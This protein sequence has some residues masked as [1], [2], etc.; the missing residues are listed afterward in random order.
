MRSGGAVSCHTPARVGDRATERELYQRQVVRTSTLFVFGIA[1]LLLLTA[2]LPTDT[3]PGER[4]GLIISAFLLAAFAIIW[5][6]LL[7]ERLLGRYRF[8]LGATTALAIIAF[9]LVT[10]GGVR[11]L[12]FPY[13]LLPIMA[14]VL[15]RTRIALATGAA[16]IAIFAVV[17]LLTAYESTAEAV[18]LALTRLIELAAVIFVT[19]ILTRALESTRHVLR[20]RTEQLAELAATD[21]LTGLYNRHFMQEHLRMLQSLAERS[22]QPYSVIALDLD[23]FKRVNDAHGH[24]V[25]DLTLRAVADAIR[26]MLR[27]S[28]VAVRTGG[29]EFAVLLANAGLDEA[30][31][32]SER[33]QESV[34]ATAN[35]VPDPPVT[36]SIGVAAWKPGR[37]AAQVLKAADALIYRAKNAGGGRV[38]AEET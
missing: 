21:Q 2:L 38:M 10:T 37:T 15:T 23:H 33:I 16:A 1:A 22:G 12:Y 8:T 11:S 17:A 7:P 30:R 14:T 26:R 29:E 27:G 18:T 20:Q 32:V 6:I 19:L 34:R 28:D 36:A 4:A 24:D 5:F 13:F 3:P 35:V 9:L 31:L 25:G